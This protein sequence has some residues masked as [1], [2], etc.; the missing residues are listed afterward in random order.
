MG[1][2]VSDD[3]RT[4]E[5]VAFFIEV[6]KALGWYRRELGMKLNDIGS[7]ISLSESAVSKYL[8]DPKMKKNFLNEDDLKKNS[9]VLLT[10]EYAL[11]IS[12][13]MGENCGIFYAYMKKMKIE[14]K[15]AQN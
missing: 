12:A 8:I 1:K 9:K 15:N 3:R 4:E 10:L 14:Q 11:K 2:K 7:Q 5:E 6:A 13:A